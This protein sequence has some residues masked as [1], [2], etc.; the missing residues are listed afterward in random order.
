M[1]FSNFASLADWYQKLIAIL[2]MVVWQWFG[3][4]AIGVIIIEKLRRP[5]RQYVV[6]PLEHILGSEP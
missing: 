2:L 3:A 4:F 1:W 6:R 5:Y